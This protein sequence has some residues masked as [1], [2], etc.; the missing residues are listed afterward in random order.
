MFTKRTDKIH[1]IIQYKHTTKKRG[2]IGVKF[3]LNKPNNN[4]NEETNRCCDA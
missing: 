4:F 3:S 1:E 2:K